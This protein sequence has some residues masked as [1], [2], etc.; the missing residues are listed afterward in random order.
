MNSLSSLHKPSWTRTPLNMMLFL[1]LISAAWTLAFASESEPM[2]SL[3][4]SVGPETPELLAAAT[5]ARPDMWLHLRIYLNIR[6][7]E[8]ARKMSDDLH[9]ASS[10]MYRKWITPKQFDELFGP[11]PASY[12]AIAS[13][14]KS[15]GFS[16]TAVRR[17]RRDVEF[18]GTVAQADHAFRVQIMSLKDGKHYGIL[19][20]PKIP[21][22]FQGAILGV[23]G[24]DNL[25]QISPAAAVGAQTGSHAL[26][27]H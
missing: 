11:L 16:V 13:W 20:D 23:M 14:L 19:S 3:P 22:R 24:L 8:A 26:V 1:L 5:P 7:K 27:N 21:A 17:D 4:G 9:N 10:P 15:Q 18:T 6:N 12:D 2:V 25:S